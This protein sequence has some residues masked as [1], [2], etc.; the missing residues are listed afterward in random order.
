MPG[1][2]VFSM[3]TVRGI[4]KLYPV[5]ILKYTV[6]YIFYY[7]CPSNL[8]RENKKTPNFAS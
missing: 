2:P 7:L 3:E 8:V 6:R 1:K 4:Y 5:F